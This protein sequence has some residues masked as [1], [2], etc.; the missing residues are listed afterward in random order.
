MMLKIARVALFA[1]L[2]AEV[3]LVVLLVSGVA[4]PRPVVIAA[5][6]VVL[7]V[8]LLEASV[9]WRR[10]RAL[11]QDGAR[12]RSALRGACEQI[13][14][15]K[16]RRV[17]GF[18]VK[19][20]VSLM[21]WAGRRRH[22]VPPGAVTLSYHREQTMLMSGFL[23]ACVVE[24]VCVEVLLRALDA[25]A[26]LRGVLLALGAYGVLFAL[27]VIAGLITRPHVVTADELRLRYGVFFDLRIPRHLVAGVQHMRNYN[28]TGTMTTDGDCLVLAANSQTNLIVELAETV[29][30]VRPLGRREHVRVLRFFAD[31]PSAAVE[32]LRR[33]R[34][35]AAIGPAG[36]AGW[37]APPG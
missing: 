19:G 1:I 24:L 13:V 14:P 34:D 15:E 5:E 2:P 21:L 26:V 6:L 20:M 3:M 30:A 23:F 29:V 11:R 22:G 10:Y 17:M 37:R 4:L 16:V 33:S 27:A 7:T 32:A 18:E 8:L 28:E 12:R 31:D 9:L 36:R 35:S 25:P